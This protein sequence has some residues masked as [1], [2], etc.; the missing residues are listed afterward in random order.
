AITKLLEGGMHVLDTTTHLD[1][2]AQD[3]E[4]YTRN[5]WSTRYITLA[6]VA[7]ELPRRR[8]GRKTHISTVYRWTAFGCRGVKLRYVQIGATRCTTR[9]WLAEF[10]E[11]L[12]AA[13]T[14]APPPI[15]SLRTPASRR[16]S[17][18]RIERELDRAG[19]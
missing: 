3:S 17:F 2:A 10:I 6:Q 4:A 15:P 14:E 12:T 13:S 16:R 18:D 7:A 1:E 5:G 8:R 9:E 11:R 19:I